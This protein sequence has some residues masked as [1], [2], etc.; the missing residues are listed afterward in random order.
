MRNICVTIVTPEIRGGNK[1]TTLRPC[2]YLN[3]GVYQKGYFHTW[4]HYSDETKSCVYALIENKTGDIIRVQ[5]HLM[6]FTDRNNM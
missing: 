1:M 4:E 2:T 5:T 6:H 3:N